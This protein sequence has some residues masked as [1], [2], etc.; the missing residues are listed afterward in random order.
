MAS[1]KGRSCASP[2]AK[3]ASATTPCCNRRGWI[4]AAPSLARRRRTLSAIGGRHFARCFPRLCRPCPRPV[5]TSSFVDA[6]GTPLCGVPFAALWELV[7]AL[8]LAVLTALVLL[9]ELF[10]GVGAFGRGPALCH[11]SPTDLNED[12]DD[13]DQDYDDED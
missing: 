2:A 1:W 8:V 12:R 10:H 6:K 3:V 9:D 7:G 4:G 13:G 5:R 11:E